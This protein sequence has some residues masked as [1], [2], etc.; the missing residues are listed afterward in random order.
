[1]RLWIMLLE[2]RLWISIRPHDLNLAR[3]LDDKKGTNC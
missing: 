3:R 1:M 2:L